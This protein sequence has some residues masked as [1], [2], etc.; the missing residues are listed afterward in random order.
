MMRINKIALKLILGI[1]GV[2]LVMGT[3]AVSTYSWFMSNAKAAVNVADPQVIG[4]DD[5]IDLTLYYFNGNGTPSAD[6]SG[7]AGYTND[8]FDNTKT[9]YVSAYDTITLAGDFTEASTSTLVANCLNFSKIR[10][11][12]RYTF[13]LRSQ[14]LSGVSVS[15]KD[16]DF[17]TELSNTHY[18]YDGSSVGTSTTNVSLVSV[19]NGY[20]ARYCWSAVDTY[21]QNFTKTK[22]SAGY[23]ATDRIT[24]SY[25]SASD[26]RTDSVAST[27]TPTKYSGAQAY[28]VP[29]AEDDI[30]FFFSIEYSDDAS[31]RLLFHSSSGGNTYYTYGSAGTFHP[32][33]G[34]SFS[35]GQI[36]VGVN[37]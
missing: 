25:T 20:S 16:I 22:A 2:V 36:R 13:A 7:Y 24:Y 4:S 19:I 5:G 26:T 8:F 23:T 21:L 11:G 28:A 30:V 9:E 15:F 29:A 18:M 35:I 3:M 12:R 33:D 17:N 14:H 10:P 1:S 32:Y 34:L 27:M 6:G 37:E 31:K